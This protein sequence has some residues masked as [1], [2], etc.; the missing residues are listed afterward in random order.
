M[1]TS[2]SQMTAAMRSGISSGR[3]NTEPFGAAFAANQPAQIR[4]QSEP[5]VTG[6]VPA[7]VLA[8]SRPSLGRCRRGPRSSTTKAEWA[9][10]GASQ[11]VVAVV[12]PLPLG[13]QDLGAGSLVR[14][15]GPADPAGGVP[16]APS[17]LP[18]PH[19]LGWGVWVMA[20]DVTICNYAHSRSPG[21][22]LRRTP[23]SAP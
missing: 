1:A 16:P 4:V 20:C 11:G 6:V 21:S 17:H 2:A 23:R 13:N 19:A 15:H 9:S 10:G 7:E 12:E 18:G 5:H 3:K 14:E 22:D 8:Q